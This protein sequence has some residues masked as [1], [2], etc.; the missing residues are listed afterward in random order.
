ME[1]LFVSKSQFKTTVFRDYFLASDSL[2]CKEQ[3][4]YHDHIQISQDPCLPDNIKAKIQDPLITQTNTTSLQYHH[5]SKY[6][7]PPLSFAG[8][9]LQAVRCNRKDD[10]CAIRKLDE[11]SVKAKIQVWFDI[12]KA[13][14]QVRFDT[15]KAKIQVWFD[16]VKAKIQVRF[17][18]VKAKIQVW[19]DIVKAKIQVRFDTVK[20]KI[21]VRFDT[22]KAKIQVR[23]DILKA[24]SGCTDL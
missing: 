20:A 17:D 6:Q 2:P 16:I 10:E 4:G 7:H 1:S 14:I 13:K 11:E 18:T 19:F 3:T 21:Q 22:V 23:F 15:V 12:V 8:Q 5:N 24:I 9:G